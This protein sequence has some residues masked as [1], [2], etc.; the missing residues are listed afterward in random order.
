MSFCT[1]V[2]LPDINPG[3]ASNGVE[4]CNSTLFTMCM[5]QGDSA[6]EGHRRICKVLKHVKVVKS[7]W[8][9]VGCIRTSGGREGQVCSVFRDTVDVRMVRECDI[10]R[11]GLGTY[12]INEI[13]R[14]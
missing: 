7:V 10:E 14:R 3:V 12:E 2:L 6:V 11:E 1:T 5:H 4:D 9:R 8:V 13:S